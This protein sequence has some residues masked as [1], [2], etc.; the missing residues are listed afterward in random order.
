MDEEIGKNCPL[1]P[2]ELCVK[3]WCGWWNHIDDECSVTTL[4]TLAT[5][6]IGG[7]DRKHD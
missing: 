3:V 7:A 1:T 5:I 6:D 4:G 2:G